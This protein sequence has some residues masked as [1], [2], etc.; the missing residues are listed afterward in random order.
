ML[1]EDWRSGTEIKIKIAINRK[2]R[3]LSSNSENDRLTAKYTAAKRGLW[4]TPKSTS[5]ELLKCVYG[6]ECNGEKTG[7][8]G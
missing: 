8:I 5:S 4:K 2:K 3:L 1:T 7:V 6:E